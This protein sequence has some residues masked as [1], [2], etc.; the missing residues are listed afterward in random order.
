MLG[1]DD[2]ENFSSRSA[3]RK[4]ADADVEDAG[5]MPAVRN[6]NGGGRPECFRM[7]RVRNGASV[8]L[9]TRVCSVAGV[10]IGTD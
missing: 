10:E 6:G 9:K 8:E 2:G 1:W 4:R 5:K 3:Q 7:Q